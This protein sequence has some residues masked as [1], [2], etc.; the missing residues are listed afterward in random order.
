M[1]D[2]IW[3][4]RQQDDGRR[5]QAMQDDNVRVRCHSACVSGERNIEGWAGRVSD[6]HDVCPGPLKNIIRE[7]EWI[8]HTC[9]YHVSFLSCRRWS[10]SIRLIYALHYYSML[11]VMSIYYWWI[12]QWSTKYLS[13]TISSQLDGMRE[14]ATTHQ[15]K[16]VLVFV[17]WSWNG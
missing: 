7:L 14:I 15:C 6:T 9:K 16:L 5:S 3:R 8:V 13:C 12:R 10:T 4:L 2:Y 17:Y 1:V 11:L